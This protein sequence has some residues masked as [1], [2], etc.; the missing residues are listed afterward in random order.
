MRLRARLRRLERSTRNLSDDLSGMSD[1]E[2]IDRIAELAEEL[3]VDD[4][5]TLME[6]DLEGFLSS[7]T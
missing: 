2:L 1:Q 5:T 3:G 4:V 6:K 7:L